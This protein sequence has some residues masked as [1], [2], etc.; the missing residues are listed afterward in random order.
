MPEPATR[1]WLLPLAAALL[2]LTSWVT[3]YRYARGRAAPSPTFR[4]VTF[5]NG[6][7]WDARFAPDGQ[8]IV[9]A[10]AWEGQPPEVFSTRFDSS[11]SRSVGLPSA[12]I[13][14]ISPTGEM[15]ISLH[16]GD[17]NGF[18]Q[19]GTLARVPLAGGALGQ[20]SALLA[21]G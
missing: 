3:V 20:P 1:R 19:S 12:L 9:Y 16:P 10:A 13:L 14:S 8:T 15:A 18:S 7:I 5:R 6:T 4:E 21:V 2:L 11:D 17:F